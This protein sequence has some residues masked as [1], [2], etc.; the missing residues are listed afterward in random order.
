MWY[1]IFGKSPEELLYAK[2]LVDAEMEG[3]SC[4]LTRKADSGLW[5]SVDFLLCARKVG[6]YSR[7]RTSDM[8]TGA[9]RE[10]KITTTTATSE[11]LPLGSGY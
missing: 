4:V 11:R 9:I 7:S 10:Q 5:N 6:V 1:W 2:K 8:V 3:L